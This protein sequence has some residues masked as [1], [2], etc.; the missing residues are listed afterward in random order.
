MLRLVRNN[1]SSKYFYSKYLTLETTK[2]VSLCG[3]LRVTAVNLLSAP[4]SPLLLTAP[5]L[6]SPDL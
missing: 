4:L 2:Q 5:P 1:L 3:G 6:G